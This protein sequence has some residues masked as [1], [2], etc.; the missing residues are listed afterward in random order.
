MPITFVPVN[1]L[2]RAKVAGKLKGGKGIG[3][4][5]VWAP[6]YHTCLPTYHALVGRSTLLGR[7]PVPQVVPS[8]SFLVSFIRASMAGVPVPPQI[9]RDVH[10][11]RD[12]SSAPSLVLLC[13]WFP[14]I[15]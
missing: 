1:Y 4:H 3:C 6:A 7:E 13:S 11:Q 15:W 14:N 12:A 5:C 9:Q 2:R 8:V 10:Y